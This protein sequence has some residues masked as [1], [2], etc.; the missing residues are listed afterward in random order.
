MSLSRVI[1]DQGRLA[2]M[3]RVRT[4]SFPSIGNCR[5]LGGNAESWYSFTA[6]CRKKPSALRK[7][8]VRDVNGR[9]TTWR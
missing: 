9:P 8:P 2:G 3:M 5:G 1:F 7:G 6:H 4:V